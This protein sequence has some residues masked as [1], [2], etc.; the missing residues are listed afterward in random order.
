MLT[1]FGGLSQE[2]TG[3][4]RLFTDD[5]FD[6]YLWYDREGGAL[7][8]FQLCYDR[9]KDPHSLTCSASGS[10]VHTRID[11]GESQ[12]AM[13]YKGSPILVSD[14]VFEKDRVLDRFALA[15]ELLDPAI[16]QKVLS[17]IQTYADR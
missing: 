12:G 14:G 7:T 4:R 6:L 3:Y 2:K 1:E 16:R 5:Y 17:A 8:G 13:H 15:S 11:D 10:C 9:V